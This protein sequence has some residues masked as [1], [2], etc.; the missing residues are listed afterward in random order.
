M[1][2]LVHAR[3][4]LKLCGRII[5]SDVEFLISVRQNKTIWNYDATIKIQEL[6]KKGYVMYTYCDVAH[7]GWW[8]LTKLGAEF[9]AT[10]PIT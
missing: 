9:I 10:Q 8:V 1:I 6:K 4:N 7:A 3:E 2:L 5:V